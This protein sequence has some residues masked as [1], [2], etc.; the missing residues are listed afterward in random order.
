MY[1]S[2]LSKN[3]GLNKGLYIYFKGTRNSTSLNA[4]IKCLLTPW[5][6]L[7]IN[8]NLLA[9]SITTVT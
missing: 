2:D 8:E 6:D 9:K 1:Q 3:L 4:Q 7:E 5:H